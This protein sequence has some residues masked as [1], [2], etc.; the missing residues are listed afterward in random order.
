MSNNQTHDRKYNII[1]IEDYVCCNF[2]PA[3]NNTGETHVA[4]VKKIQ[5]PGVMEVIPLKRN[6]T[7]WTVYSFEVEKMCKEEVMLWLLEN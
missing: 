5:G 1:N 6:A 2:S 3:I 7:Q 4:K